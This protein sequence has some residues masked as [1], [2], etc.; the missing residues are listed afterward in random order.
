MHIASIPNILVDINIHPWSL[1]L[2]CQNKSNDFSSL[3]NANILI[4]YLNTYWFSL[5]KHIS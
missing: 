1:V 2:P 5:N 3:I 4:F